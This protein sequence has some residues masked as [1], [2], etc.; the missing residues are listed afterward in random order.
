MRTFLLTHNP[1]LWNQS[2]EE[3]A[4]DR[5]L[6]AARGTAPGR[7]STGRRTDIDVGDRVYLLRQGSLLSRGILARGW[8]EREPFPAPHWDGGGG[9]ANYVDVQWDA[10]VDIE[11]P[12]PTDLLLHEVPQVPWNHLMSSGI[13]VSDPDAVRRLDELW[14]RHTGN[15]PTVPGSPRP[16]DEKR[17]RGQDHV[18]DAMVRT[19]VEDHAQ[20]VLMEHYTEDGWE[21]ED[22]RIG[23][24]FD[25]IATKDGKV[26]FLEA[27][28]TQSSGGAVFVT[29]NEVQFART[30]P[31]RTF[32]GIV[33]NIE[34]VEDGGKIVG[35]GGDLSVVAWEP[36]EG[37]LRP[38]QFQWLPQTLA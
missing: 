2:D 22:R 6:I 24:P 29:A 33:A 35:R 7:W 11:D 38:L 4:H 37:E 19:A 26:I 30:H 34:V 3:W 8:V 27:K 13:Q 21:V 23:N 14:S 25:G 5:E 16:R 28:G 12:L 15:D 36:D 20:R 18:R 1:E 31:G 10:M 32:M 17:S 9:D